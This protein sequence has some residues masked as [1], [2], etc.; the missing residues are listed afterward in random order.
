MMYDGIMAYGGPSFPGMLVCIYFIILF[1]CGN[2]ILCSCPSPRPYPC[3]YPTP[4]PYP[5]PCPPTP[6]RCPS[7]HPA[8][9]APALSLQLDANRCAPQVLTWGGPRALPP[10]EAG[11]GR[12][13][14]ICP[15]QTTSAAQVSG[16]E[17]GAWGRGGGGGREL[18]PSLQFQERVLAAAVPASRHH[19]RP[20]CCACSHSLGPQC[21][22]WLP[23]P[24]APARG[25][26]S[27][28]PGSDIHLSPCSRARVP[29]S[30]ATLQDVS[31]RQ[32]GQATGRFLSPGLLAPLFP[33]CPCRLCAQ[34]L[35]K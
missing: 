31:H 18:S 22:H 24:R 10:G 30:E 15:A 34:G 6:P 35:G 32:S 9:A 11:K 4:A 5:T 27:L 2:C 14:R 17:P 13:G 20:Q 7:P 21:E 1:I 28:R 29:P 12:L 23:Q 25:G 16:W 33:S 19:P 26:Q 3:P 8:P